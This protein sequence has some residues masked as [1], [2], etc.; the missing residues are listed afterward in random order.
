MAQDRGVC[1]AVF[2]SAIIIMIG[3]ITT[4][5][6][7]MECFNNVLVFIRLLLVQGILY[8]IENERISRNFSTQKHCMV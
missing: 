6:L 1:V 3:V 4:M 2:L 7:G 5:V 8:I